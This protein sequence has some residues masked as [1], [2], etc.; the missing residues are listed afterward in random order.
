MRRR[1]EQACQRSCQSRRDRSGE[2]VIEV[3]DEVREGAEDVELFVEECGRGER[4]GAVEVDGGD[5]G[6]VPREASP[7]KPHANLP[8]RLLLP[9]LCDDAAQRGAR[10]CSSRLRPNTARLLLSSSFP[11]SPLLSLTLS[12]TLT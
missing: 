3:I 5:K 1:G 9:P 2:P 8:R 6:A 7:A 4:D 10:S 11:P 12:L